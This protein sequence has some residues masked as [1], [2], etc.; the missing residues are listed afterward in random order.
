MN[1]LI[2]AFVMCVCVVGCNSRY[3]LKDRTG[4]NSSV[5]NKAG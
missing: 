3:R 4:A 1:R 5:D 2:G